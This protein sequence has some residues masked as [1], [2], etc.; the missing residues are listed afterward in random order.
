MA[1]TKM[2]LWTVEDYHCMVEA[3]ILKIRDRVKL[4]EGQIIEMSPQLPPHASTTLIKGDARSAT[5]LLKIGQTKRS[6][7]RSQTLCLNFRFYTA[8]IVQKPSSDGSS[9]ETF[10]AK[11]G[12]SPLAMTT[13]TSF[14]AIG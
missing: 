13:M 3:G 2:R 14:S 10:R 12:E 8:P 7:K 11:S 9:R 4:L 5:K 1:L 6:S